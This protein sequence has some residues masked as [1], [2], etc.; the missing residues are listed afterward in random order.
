MDWISA[1]LPALINGLF[2]GGR[3]AAAPTPTND[4][5]GPGNPGNA[6]LTYGASTPADQSAGGFGSGGILGSS[7][8]SVLATA[9]FGGINARLAGRNQRIYNKTAYPGTVPWEQMGTGSA[10]AQAGNMASPELMQRER[11]SRRNAQVALQTS[12]MNATA[13]LAGHAMNAGGA[14]AGPLVASLLR[15]GGILPPGVAFDPRIMVRG[16]PEAEIAS[17]EAGAERTRTMLPYEVDESFQNARKKEMESLMAP[18]E[19]ALREW[20]ARYGKSYGGNEARGLAESVRES[21]PDFAR[22]ARDTDDIL[23]KL[24]NMIEDKFGFEVM[25]QFSDIYDF[26]P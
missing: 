2:G 9:L 7:L 4:V 17:L 1:L 26:V 20:E 25:K 15:A 14:A 5:F 19:F 3:R 22:G 18:F 11:E 8:Q 10:G 24:L 13:G 21:L 6:G 16:R 12:R 23:P